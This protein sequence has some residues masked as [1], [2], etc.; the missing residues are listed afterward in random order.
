MAA[1]SNP[2]TKARQ[3]LVTLEESDH[4]RSLK[5][6]SREWAEASRQLGSIKSLEITGALHRARMCAGIGE[7]LLMLR[8]A[9][10]YVYNLQGNYFISAFL[11]RAG[12]PRKQM[13]D[14]G[15]VQVYLH[16]WLTHLEGQYRSGQ[17]PFGRQ[18]PSPV[19]R[20]RPVPVPVPVRL[21]QGAQQ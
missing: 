3:H 15:A 10:Q 12:V 16:R 5:S 14:R 7:D 19:V 2:F 1:A 8:M 9:Q 17:L 18:R 13:L 11:I 4:L 6:R 21:Q 20:A